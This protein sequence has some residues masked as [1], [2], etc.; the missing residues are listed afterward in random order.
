MTKD[1]IAVVF[2]GQSPEHEVS[3]TSA[4]TVLAHMD[5]SRL[6]VIPIYVSIEGT[7]NIPPRPLPEEEY[8]RALDDLISV[9]APVNSNS[10]YEW[11]HYPLGVSP[12]AND[13]ERLRDLNV[14]LVMIL[15]HGQGGEDGSL[16]ARFESEGIAYVG[17]GPE[18]SVVCM[19]K[20]R[21]LEIIADED[22]S[23]PDG[24]AFRRVGDKWLNAEWGGGRAL[25]LSE[26]VGQVR[27]P[28][29]WVVKPNC[30]GSS[31]GVTI[32]KD[33]DKL[34]D[35]ILAAAE[36][37]DVILVEACISGIEVTCGVLERWSE[38]INAFETIALQPTQIVP[39]HAT[40]FDYEAKYIPGETMEITPANLE[41]EINERI[42]NAALVAH[43]A[44]GC[45]GFSRT[46]MIV[47][48][49]KPCV[50]ELNTI[51]GMTPT[52]LLPQGAAAIGIDFSSLLEV[53]IQA[54]LRIKV[55][56]A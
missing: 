30:G 7:W 18:A 35:A 53:M 27:I 16:Q 37:D 34:E 21:A 20:R 23:V 50:L 48:N 29:P 25:T 41:H 33:Y 3:I 17:S 49:G 2:G 26:A 12:T 40:F 32:V 9:V 5:P 55:Q 54:A 56:S 6:D 52:S 14:D 11:R 24:C 8:G 22:L 19:D 31:V 4:R 46:D 45:R 47:S 15:I 28:S 39:R 1:R 13:I 44:L 51:P 38:K 42:R 43:K 36:V 10:R